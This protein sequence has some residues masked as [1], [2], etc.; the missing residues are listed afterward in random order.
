MHNAQCT[1]HNGRTPALESRIPLC[2]RAAIAALFTAVAFSSSADII[3]T[4]LTAQ[5]WQQRMGEAMSA[6]SKA[7]NQS[8][9]KVYF[10]ALDTA[11]YI[12]TNCPGMEPEKKLA[13]LADCGY[14]IADTVLSKHGAP[15]FNQI[16]DLKSSWKK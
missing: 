15:V 1:M 10:D 7:A 6:F 4:N 3:V 5:N 12:A 9:P 13:K 11:L 16:V 2:A 8:D 14:Y